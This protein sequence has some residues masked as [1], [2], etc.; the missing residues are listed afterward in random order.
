MQL[1]S[2]VAVALAYDGCYCSDSTPSLAISICHTCGPKKT[3]KKNKVFSN[4]ILDNETECFMTKHSSQSL[5]EKEFLL[6]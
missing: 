2:H 3:K 5:G 4:M 6:V 1:G